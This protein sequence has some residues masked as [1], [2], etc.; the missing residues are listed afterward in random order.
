MNRGK[1]KLN[2][3]LELVRVEE[4]KKEVNAPSVIT[5]EIPDGLK[6]MVT[7]RVHTSKAV[8][9]H[10]YKVLGYE[11]IGNEE[12]KTQKRTKDAEEKRAQEVEQAT[13]EAF[14]QVRDG[15]AALSEYDKARCEIINRNRREY[16]Y[17]DREFDEHGNPRE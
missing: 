3:N 10:E 9:R 15:E 14:Y 11:E 2:E 12:L 17:D 16:N 1:F 8:L 6:S 13:T 4:T 5:D 7:G